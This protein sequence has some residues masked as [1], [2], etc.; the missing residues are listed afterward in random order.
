VQYEIEVDGQVRTVV[1][2]RGSDGRFLVQTDGR[3]WTVDAS[4]ING[5]LLSLLIAQSGS[6]AVDSRE[7]SVTADPITGQLLVGV[8][9]APVSV[10]LN[11]RRRW[12]RRDDA[13]HAGG[14]PQRIVAPMPGKVVRIA[15]PPGTVVA[16]RQP[17]VV[18]EA[19]KMENEL[20]AVKPGTV[21]EVMVQEGQS[22]EAGTLLAIVS[23]A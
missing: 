8:A 18:I 4:R 10:S 23:P 22:V 14:G 2:T 13:A 19:M 21:T 17:V 12:S 16:Q 6:E 1:L 9:A 15:A 11:T 7:L 20:R 5:Q 3:E